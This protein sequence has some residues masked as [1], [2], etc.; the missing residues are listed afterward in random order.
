MEQFVVVTDSNQ[1][2]ILVPTMPAQVEH[3][4]VSHRTDQLRPDLTLTLKTIILNF[5]GIY[6]AAQK[7]C[8]KLLDM[9]LGLN[10]LESDVK[11]SE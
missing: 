4:L 1:G 8:L 6:K 2:L 5:V 3:A 11:E 10:G 9:K 7:T